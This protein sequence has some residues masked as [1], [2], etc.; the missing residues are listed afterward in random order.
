MTFTNRLDAVLAGLFSYSKAVGLKPETVVQ[1]ATNNTRLL[2]AMRR[3][4]A[5]LDADLKL[6]G[7]YMAANPPPVCGLAE[8]QNTEKSEKI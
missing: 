2:P 3:R 5:V 6:I 4:A 7:L 8:G 1:Y